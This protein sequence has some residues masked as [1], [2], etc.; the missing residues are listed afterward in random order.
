V[1]KTGFI[2]VCYTFLYDLV[3]KLI[4]AIGL[5]KIKSGLLLDLVI[6]RMM[7]LS[8]KLRS[9]ELLEE[10]FGIK[11]RRQSYYKSVPKWLALKA[12]VESIALAF[13]RAHY[14]FNFE[15]LF[16]D[17]STLYFEAFEEDE[18]R[19]NGFSKDNKSQQPQVLVVLM[20]SRE[21][22]PIAYEVFAGNIF[23]GHTI[24]PVV[25]RFIRKNKIKELTVVADAAMI[26]TENIQTLTEKWRQLHRR[27]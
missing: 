27:G 14:A 10:C 8:F 9:I 15:L 12:K 25:K 1:D 6:L 21:G 4:L 13:A 19:K 26:S 5:D 22:F 2:G 11:H 20:V 3:S 23:E 7:E 16:Y 18:L 17:V 24:I